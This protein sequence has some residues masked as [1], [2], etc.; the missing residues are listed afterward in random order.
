MWDYNIGL[1]RITPF[2][3][4]CKYSKVCHYSSILQSSLLTLLET[5][6][7]RALGLNSGLREITHSI[8]GG[9]LAA[10]GKLFTLTG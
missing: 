8:T 2:F 7:A 5:T 3:K 9:A 1:V 10:Q 4:S 6:P